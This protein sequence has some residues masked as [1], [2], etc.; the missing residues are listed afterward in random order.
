MA[1]TMIHPLSGQLNNFFFALL[2]IFFVHA[3]ALRSLSVPHPSALIEFE[4]QKPQWLSKV[5]PSHWLT[6][7]WATK[8]NT[9]GSI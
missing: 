3:S 7:L 5:R 1:F 2:F 6:F 9:N 8:R 4:F